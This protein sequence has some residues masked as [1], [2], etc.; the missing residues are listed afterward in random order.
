MKVK[1]ASLVFIK[2]P[3]QVGKDAR[4]K[5]MKYYF[6]KAIEWVI[7]TRIINQTKGKS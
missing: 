2:D 7:K 4:K 3:S 1:E 5:A 6:K